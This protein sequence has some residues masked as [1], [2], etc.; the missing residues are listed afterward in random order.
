MSNLPPLDETQTEQTETATLALGCF[1]GPDARFG[2]VPGVVRTRVGYCGG[3]KP[4]PTYHDL[5]RHTE[6]VEIDFDPQQIS[7]E[8]LLGLYFASHNPRRPAIK[9]QYASVIFY[10]GSEQREVAHAEAARVADELGENISTDI[11]EAP[12]FWRAE[13]RHQKYRLQRLGEVFEEYRERFDT[14]DDLVD[15]TAVAR[16]NGYAAGYGDAAKFADDAPQL[17]LSDHALQQIKQRR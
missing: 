10:H 15:S 14:F 3:Q 2:V 4:Q 6:T 1:W 16:A 17:G 13:D 9:R 5:G 12:T 7:Y 11:V 8:A